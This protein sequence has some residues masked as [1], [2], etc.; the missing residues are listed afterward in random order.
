MTTEQFN[1]L[2][3]GSMRP[4][5]AADS[6]PLVCSSPVMLNAIYT[7]LFVLVVVL[8]LV[9]LFAVMRW[10]DDRIEALVR[11][12]QRLSVQRRLS[13]AVTSMVDEINRRHS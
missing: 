10:C 8:C 12:H 4:L 6:V 11:W 5:T 2:V 3:R 9:G 13:N 1:E 7:L